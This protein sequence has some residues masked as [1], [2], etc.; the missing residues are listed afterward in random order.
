[1]NLYE[2]V[3]ILNPS[4]TEEEHKSAL[5]KI[6]D[7]ITTSGGS[8]LKIDNWGKKRLAYEIN[9]HKTGSYLLFQFN[10]PSSTIRRMEDF[11]KVFDPVIKFMAIRLEKKQAA[12]L[13]KRMAEAEAK[14]KADAVEVRQPESGQ[15]GQTSVQ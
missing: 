9:K 1:M 6:S 8:I 13:M 12:A 14:A 2:K 15:P 10:A 5:D 3:V 7:L 4:L 11:F